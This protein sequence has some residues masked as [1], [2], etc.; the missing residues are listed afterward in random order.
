LGYGI[1]FTAVQGLLYNAFADTHGDPGNSQLVQSVGQ[2]VLNIDR[3]NGSNCGCSFPRITVGQIT[4][5]MSYSYAAGNNWWASVL[6][7]DPAINA[8]INAEALQIS[9]FNREKAWGWG[10]YYRNN[11]QLYSNYLATILKNWTALGGCTPSTNCYISTP[12]DTP[13]PVIVPISHTPTP[14]PKPSVTP[15]PTKGLTAT[16]KPTVTPSVTPTPATVTVI[17]TATPSP[18]PVIIV[19]TATPTE[20]PSP[21]TEPTA[22]IEPTAS[23]TPTPSEI[24]ETGNSSQS[25]QS[26]LPEVTFAPIIGINPQEPPTGTPTPP[27]DKTIVAGKSNAIGIL[28]LLGIIFALLLVIP[29]T[30]RKIFFLVRKVLGHDVSIFQ[31]PLKIEENPENKDEPKI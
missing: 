4:S 20:S 23:P 9:R 25:A 16:P 21:T 3:S 12:T 26:P 8:Y 14:S 11:W 19:V 5:G 24:A 18:T 27:P 30:R 7:R 6:S 10:S 2:N 28:S 31:H 17:V 29:V 15:T 22:T 1:Q 13:V